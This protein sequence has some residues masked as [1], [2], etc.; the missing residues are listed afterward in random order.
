MITV[1]ESVLCQMSLNL[2]KYIKNGI[3]DVSSHAKSKK[4]LVHAVGFNSA[5]NKDM[6]I[7][8]E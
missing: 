6:E 1:V 4:K 3:C 8:F 7:T 2:K 5:S